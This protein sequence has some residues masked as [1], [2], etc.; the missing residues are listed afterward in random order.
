M[1]TKTFFRILTIAGILSTTA[2]MAQNIK[3][4]GGS[5][6]SV[7]LSEDGTIYTWGANTNYQLARDTDKD[8][9]PFPKA[10][11]ETLLPPIIAVNTSGA[12]SIALGCDGSVFTWGEASNGKLGNGLTTNAEGETCSIGINAPGNCDSP[13]PIQVIAGESGDGFLKDIIAVSASASNC[14]AITSD[15][16]LLAW[17]SNMY[18]QLGN[19]NKFEE[20]KMSSSPVYVDI[21]DVIATSGTDFGAYA[22]VDPDGDSI[23]T[24]YGW[25]E[26][27]NRNISPESD[28]FSTP[29]PILKDDSTELNNITMI[30]GGATHGL[31]LDTDGQVWAI[32]GVWGGGNQLGNFDAE[33]SPIKGLATK[34]LAG[35]QSDMP[36]FEH[37]QYL[38]NV[39]QIAAGQAH[40]L[41]IVEI[42]GERYAM[43]WGTNK[44]IT[45]A[46]G[47]LGTGDNKSVNV[48]VFVMKNKTEKLTN[49]QSISAGYNHS[50]ATTHNLKNNVQNTYIWGGNSFGEIGDNTTTD[51][52]YPT[53]LIKSPFTPST[54]CPVAN[55]GPDTLWVSHEEMDINIRKTLQLNAG[56]IGNYTYNWS[57]IFEDKKNQLSFKEETAKVYR[58]G[59]YYV[60]ISPLSNDCQNCKE[61]TDSVLIKYRTDELVV[62]LNR[63]ELYYD[64]NAIATA[65][66]PDNTVKL[67]WL[68]G[69]PDFDLNN[70]S[71][72]DLDAAFDS[73]T[74]DEFMKGSIQKIFTYDEASDYWAVAELKDGTLLAKPVNMKKRELKIVTQNVSINKELKYDFEFDKDF[75]LAHEPSTNQNKNGEYILM[76]IA[77]HASSQQLIKHSY[78]NYYT[79]TAKEGFNGTDTAIIEFKANYSN[80][81]VDSLTYA[82]KR[83]ILNIHVDSSLVP[84]ETSTNTTD[85]TDDVTADGAID[86]SVSGG[87]KPY[88]FV[89][90][91]GA[92][93]EDLNAVKAGTYTVTITDGILNSMIDTVV[94]SVKSSS[95]ISGTVLTEDSGCESC[96]LMLFKKSGENISLLTAVDTKSDGTYKFDKLNSGKY[97]LLAST[98][99]NQNYLPTFAYD[100]HSAKDAYVLDLTGIVTQFDIKLQVN[101]ETATG[102]GSISGTITNDSG[103]GAEEQIVLLNNENEEVIAWAEIDLEGNYSFNNLVIGNYEAVYISDRNIITTEAA[104]SEKTPSA[105]IS[106]NI[107]EEDNSSTAIENQELP[108]FEIFPQP[109][110]KIVTVFGIECQNIKI[111][112][113]NGKL[114]AEANDSQSINI[115]QLPAGTYILT[116]ENASTAVSKILL[117]P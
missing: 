83:I 1:Y 112:N 12:T 108:D 13:V 87:K 60:K 38:K 64:E 93:T 23:G 102:N 21:D 11:D 101:N 62:N 52:L 20:Q 4:D 15:H 18:G 59:M 80:K 43:A 110:T 72:E 96:K 17:G 55:L 3:I 105:T 117:K 22:L 113:I 29:V 33:Y 24:V 25:G 77:D 5:N 78:P 86:L 31:F 41:A 90:S 91:N 111:S 56:C 94:V 92:T 76:N 26:N 104:L 63:G 103:S 57:A 100:S 9:D 106:F 114:V 53:A 70:L 37:S 7:A 27:K 99:N 97:I 88:S 45:G 48:P 85:A 98:T 61:S 44:S 68:Y 115:E 46:Q 36:G 30:A 2:S 19:G 35:A 58:E 10:I 39:K 71:S 73:Y 79:Y 50:F 8:M 49:V 67:Y 16:R 81:Y 66:L 84:F 14:Y 47:M 116:A 109:A 51:A 28:E 40:S 69:D 89:W 74:E 42:N 34:V 75:F 82:R 54:P 6:H 107:K 32:G 65:Y 95:S